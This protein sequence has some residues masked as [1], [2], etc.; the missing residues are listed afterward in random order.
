MQHAPSI[1]Q[2]L[3]AHPPAFQRKLA[4]HLAT[5]R[6][7]RLRRSRGTGCLAAIPARG[8]PIPACAECRE[9]LALSIPCPATHPPPAPLPQH[10][11]RAR[12]ARATAG[13][14]KRLSP[15]LPSPPRRS[16]GRGRARGGAAHRAAWRNRHASAFEAAGA[17]S[18]SS[19][20]P[21]GRRLST[22]Q[23][24]PRSITTATGRHLASRPP[25]CPRSCRSRRPSRRS[26][27]AAT[28]SA[29]PTSSPPSSC[30]S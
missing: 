26:S 23:V 20:A 30:A 25:S 21:G 5:S 29:G 16:R 4:Q 13:T 3:P 12:L 28:S 8:P 11:G 27:R 14:R 10:A 6:P 18:A 9:L 24:R 19:A 17:G 7:A 1:M 2:L 15:G 22:A